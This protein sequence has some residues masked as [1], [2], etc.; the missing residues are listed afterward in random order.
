MRELGA[1]W[2]KNS[3]S[4]G[5]MPFALRADEVGFR[6]ISH[7][8]NESAGTPNMASYRVEGPAESG[9]QRMFL[10]IRTIRAALQR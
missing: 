3:Y 6:R 4:T 5:V 10:D 1:R 9:P 7:T 8:G 2:L